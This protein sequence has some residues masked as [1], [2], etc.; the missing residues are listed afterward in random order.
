[1]S[2]IANRQ[3]SW[4]TEEDELLAETVIRHIEQGSTQLK[5]FEEVGE[6]LSRTPAACGFRWNSVVRK[7]YRDEIERA[8]GKRKKTKDKNEE[9]NIQIDIKKL[10][11][12]M[13]ITYLQYLEAS[14]QDNLQDALKKEKQEKQEIKRKYESLQEEY[15]QLKEEYQS[16]KKA[17]D[18]V[19]EAIVV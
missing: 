7:N 1:M 16:L 19:K 4:T 5:A 17:L 9:E 18:K 14:E 10:S 11:L 15:N 3:D 13:V 12:S 8:R 2:K 6:K